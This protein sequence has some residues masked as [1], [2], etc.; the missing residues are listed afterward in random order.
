MLPPP[1]ALCTPKQW[2]Q[3]I[4]S[5]PPPP[6]DPKAC[7]QHCLPPPPALQVQLSGCRRGPHPS[8]RVRSTSKLQVPDSFRLRPV[9]TS[10]M[11]FSSVHFSDTQN[12]QEIKDSSTIQ[13]LC[14]LYKEKKKKKSRG[15]GG[16]K[17]QGGRRLG[18]QIMMSQ[19]QAY[20][21]CVT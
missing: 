11:F 21:W 5:L 15:W 10:P 7:S 19:K 12:S 1:P 2:I 8:G 14:F 20:C 16:R 9:I 17:E 18:R 3:Q 13:L 4:G 6:R